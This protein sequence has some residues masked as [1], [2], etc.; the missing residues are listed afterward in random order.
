M[1]DEVPPDSDSQFKKALEAFEQMIIRIG[2]P[3][4]ET[5][6]PEEELIFELAR[7]MIHLTKALRASMP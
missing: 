3:R 4:S 7:G 6:E 1:F 5:M 2:D